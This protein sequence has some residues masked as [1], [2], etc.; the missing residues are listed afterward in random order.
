MK[1]VNGFAILI[2]GLA[3]LF[4]ASP[5][6]AKRVSIQDWQCEFQIEP[7][8][9]GVLFMSR[10]Q[11][12]VRGGIKSTGGESDLNHRIEGT[13][14]KRELNINRQFEPDDEFALSAIIIRTSKTAAVMAGRYGESYASVVVGDC[15]FLDERFIEVPDEK[16]ETEKPVSRAG[17]STTTKMLPYKPTTADRPEFSVTAS[18]SDGVRSIS[19]V[20]DGRVVKRCNSSSCKYRAPRLSAGKH[21]WRADAVSKSGYQN[22]KYPKEFN[23][24]KVAQTGRCSIKGRA[25]GGK[26]DM[27]R[28][29]VVNL[30][31]PDNNNNF[32]ASARFTNGSYQFNRLPA[33][34][35]QMVVDTRADTPVGASPSPT[36]VRCDSTGTVRRNFRFR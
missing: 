28:I 33:G 7:G 22:P 31:G 9:D 30:F 2:L 1:N 27:S 15:E 8:V 10:S 17:P 32:R 13:W 23:V 34:R 20:L 6:E 26:A 29:F 14:V 16:P 25:T 5:A 4:A 18:H 11:G 35:Y 24:S 12:K 21:V 19:I 36:T 3:V